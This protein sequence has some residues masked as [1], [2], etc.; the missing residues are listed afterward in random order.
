MHIGNK[1][2]EEVCKKGIS[3]TDFAKRIKKSR[4]YLYSI[5]KKEN[6]D[7]DLLI[8]IAKV[9]E[10]SPV[11]F[12]EEVTP[13]IIQNGKENILV[14]QDNNGQISVSECQDRLKDALLE[15]EHLKEIIDEKN[16]LIE[17][18]ERLITVLMNK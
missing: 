7:T 3:I 16:K 5:L 1:I 4:P 11:I 14:G 9:L 12:F 6:L 10:V 17:E 15:I 8:Q 18:K 2:K 13:N